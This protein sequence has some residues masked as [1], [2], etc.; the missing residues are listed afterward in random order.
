MGV[1]ANFLARLIERYHWIAYVGLAVI[2]FVALK[3]IYEGVINPKVG[4]LTLFS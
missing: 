3:M 4:V 1:A 2:F